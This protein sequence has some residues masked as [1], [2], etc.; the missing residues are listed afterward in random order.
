MPSATS[1][2]MPSVVKSY[3]SPS[4]PSSGTSPAALWPNLKSSPT[5]TAAA[6]SR[7]TSTARTNSSGSSRENSSVKGST[8]TAS[9]P[10]P[11]SSSARRR[12]EHRNGGMAARPDHL[13]RMRV[14][15]DHHDRQVPLHA[16]LGRAGD[17]AL[18]ATVHAVEF[19][20]RDDGLTPPCRHIVKPVPAVH[21]LS[22][23]R[24]RT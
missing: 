16:D 14:E 10:R 21:A 6:C 22:F 24:P 4:L 19:A 5:T 13:V 8:Q 23:A 1:S 7:S 12:A 11:A 17:D 18:M 15:G 3:F 2:G 9:A 20:D